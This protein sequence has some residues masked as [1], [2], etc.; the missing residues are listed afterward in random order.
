M[1]AIDRALGRLDSVGRR[2]SS[3]EKEVEGVVEEE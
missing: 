2:R 1:A 3:P